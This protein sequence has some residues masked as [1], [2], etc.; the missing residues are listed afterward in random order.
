VGAFDLIEIKN[1][2]LKEKL[3]TKWVF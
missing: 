2:L 3:I 1:I